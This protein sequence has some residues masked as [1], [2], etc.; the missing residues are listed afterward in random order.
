MNDVGGRDV[1]FFAFKNEKDLTWF[2]L[3]WK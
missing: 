3:R 1:L 2:K